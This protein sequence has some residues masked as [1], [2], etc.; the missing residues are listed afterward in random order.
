MALMITKEGSFILIGVGKENP[1]KFNC[2]SH[3]ITSYTGRI[4][5]HF[6]RLITQLIANDTE[7]QFINLL[8][9]VMRGYTYRFSKVEPFITVIDKLDW[10]YIPDECPKGFVKWCEE[11]DKNISGS[12]LMQFKT[13][14]AMNNLP[15]EVLETYEF[16]K[17]YISNGERDFFVSLSVEKKTLICKVFKTSMKAFSWMFQSDFQN[18]LDKLKGYEIRNQ[19]W[20]KYV[21]VNRGFAYNLEQ[22]DSAV[23]KE[24]N[25][26]ILAWED[27]FRAIESLSNEEYVI[28]V[29]SKMED[30]TNEGKQQNNCVGYYYH[31]SIAAH[32]NFV[33][34]VRKANNPEH[35]FMTC[36]FNFE[37]YKMNTCE[38]RYVN[39]HQ[40]KRIDLLNEIDEMIRQIF[41]EE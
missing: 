6:P 35:S 13:E 31:D 37:A 41:R 25:D 15:K 33:Y 22:I 17:D 8:K 39:N 7:S 3:E 38:F 40:A 12:S 30:F 26:K 5:Q 29:P 11:N 21:D 16:F 19:E 32:K 20:E 18:F 9:E 10:G 14:K 27:K 36:R 34:F 4:V 1:V 23:H 24:R 2:V 28:I